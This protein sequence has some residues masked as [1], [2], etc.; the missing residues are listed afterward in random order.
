[1]KVKKKP[2]EPF[3]LVDGDDDEDDDSDTSPEKIAVISESSSEKGS[4]TRVSSK[5]ER[6]EDLRPMTDIECILAVPRVKGFDLNEKE[7]C[8]NLLSIHTP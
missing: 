3:E 5:L 2:L 8:K 6:N 1:M 4:R 7:W